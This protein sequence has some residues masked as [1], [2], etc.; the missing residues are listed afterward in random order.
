[1]DNFSQID[2]AGYL[3]SVV[4]PLL[5]NADALKIDTQEDAGGTFLTMECDPADMGR[6]IGKNG[7][8]ANSFKRLVRQYGLS[9]G[10]KISIRI[11]DPRGGSAD[12]S[13]LD[14]TTRSE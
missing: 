14:E 10:V 11:T 3:K 4:Q 9:R 13:A 8:T 7:V 6:V 1:M 2:A 5:G 12:M